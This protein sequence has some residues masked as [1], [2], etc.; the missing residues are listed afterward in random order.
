MRKSVAFTTS[1]EK[2]EF[3]STSSAMVRV[4]AAAS[5][6]IIWSLMTSF[7]TFSGVVVAE[8]VVAHISTLTKEE[9][10]TNIST[11]NSSQR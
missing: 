8:G 9:A 5:S 11:S 7:L 3:D 1:K 2:R 6:S 10:D 4:E